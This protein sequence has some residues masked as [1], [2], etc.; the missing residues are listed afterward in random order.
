M[1]EFNLF[2]DDIKFTYECN[3]DTISFL[4]LKVISSN[5][6][7]ITSH[8]SKPSDCHQYLHHGSCHL[9]HTKRSIVYIKRVWSQESDFNEHS[10]NLRS[11]FLEQGY[12]EKIIK[13][14]MNKVKLNVDNKRWNNRQKKRIP[15]AVAFHPKLKV[16][17]S[18]I[19]KHLYLLYINNEVKRV[20]TSKP[21]VSFRSSRK[22]SSSNLVRAKLYP[23][24]RTVGS[25]RCGSKRCEVCKYI[26]ETD[27][28]T[29]SITGETYK[30]NHRL[31]C[32]DK[33]LVYLLTCNKCKKQCTGQT[34][35]VADGTIT[36]IRKKVLQE[37]KSA[38]KNIYINILKVKG[39]LSFSMMFQ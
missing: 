1:T 24:E 10:L 12:P 33:C 23:T 8:Y 34:T 27:T 15:F 16:L 37:E 30:I 28:F 6:K 19:N 36:S 39:I 9:A 38:Q 17:Q 21:M 14:E 29:S 31:D 22:I 25:F 11:W 13:T 18:I 4:D 3:K 35:F 26:T 20:F 5:G 7:L 2:S 32:N